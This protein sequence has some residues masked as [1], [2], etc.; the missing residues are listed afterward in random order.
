MQKKKIDVITK[1]PVPSEFDF[2]DIQCARPGFLTRVLLVLAPNWGIARLAREL[3]Y[4]LG[5][6]ARR[7]AEA[8]T[9]SQRVDILPAIAGGRGFQIVLDRKLSFYFFQDGDH[10]VYDGWEIG[11]YE[12][13]DV[14]VF[15]GG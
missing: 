4:P 5:A 10:F 9:K 1:M 11:D 7:A 2:D 13:G 15:D 6:E 12:K 14:S 8:F 3:G